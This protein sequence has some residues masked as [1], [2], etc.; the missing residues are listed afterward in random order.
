MILG[1][2]VTFGTPTDAVKTLQGLFLELQKITGQASYNPLPVGKTV[3]DGEVHFQTVRAILF[4]ADDLRE[5]LPGFNLLD[6]IPGLG[7]LI[8]FVRGVFGGVFGEVAWAALPS[9]VK[10][11]IVNQVKALASALDNKITQAIAALAGGGTS[12]AQRA[13]QMTA[14]AP[15]QASQTTY[16]PETQ[17][18]YPPGSVAVRDP[19]AGVFRILVP[20]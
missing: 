3:P 12:A 5:K 9:D 2:N 4:A 14:V 19:V 11:T 6:D 15:T 1:R 10:S 7:D 17:T 16:T 8:S 18:K 20:V 13:L